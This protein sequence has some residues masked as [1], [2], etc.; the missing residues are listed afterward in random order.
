MLT[1]YILPL[2]LPYI[3]L[4]VNKKSITQISNPYNIL[5]FVYYSKMSSS[6]KMQALVK[7]TAEAKTVIT[8]RKEETLS[9]EIWEA[10]EQAANKG[11]FT[12]SINVYEPMSRKICLDLLRKEGFTGEIQSNAIH[13]SWQSNKFICSEKVQ[14][15]QKKT[16]EMDVVNKE[17]AEKNMIKYIWDK[18]NEAAANG[19]YS[20]SLPLHY[21]ECDLCMRLAAQEGFT[22][23]VVSTNNVE[24]RWDSNI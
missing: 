4:H 11:E 7:K 24:I 23:G 21:G 1:K 10:V 16:A 2:L 20:R 17:R 5:I 19:E 6:T 14:A 18:A 3:R 8:K 12:C 13:I 15:L 22:I 9:K